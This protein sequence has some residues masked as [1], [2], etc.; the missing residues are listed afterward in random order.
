M[1]GNRTRPKISDDLK[2]MC[3]QI[4]FSVTSDG[5]RYLPCEVQ[6]GDGTVNPWVYIQ[7]VGGWLKKWALDPEDDPDMRVVSIDEVIHIRSS[8]YRIP[9]AIAG[10]VYANKGGRQGIR[11]LRFEL[12]DGMRVN[13]IAEGSAIDF[14]TWPG[15]VDPREVVDVRVG[16]DLDPNLPTITGADYSWCLFRE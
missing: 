13:C 11:H 15:T 2:T 12:K 10:R 3:S 9:A 6:L 8:P 4:P 16:V 14:L 1:S 5:Y 7:E